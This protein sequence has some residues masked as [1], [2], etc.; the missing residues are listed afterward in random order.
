MSLFRP[1]LDC[2]V[3]KRTGTNIYGEE[4][5]GVPVAARCSVIEMRMGI[6][7][8]SVRADSSASRG[9]AR[10]YIGEAK[11]LFPATADIDLD[12]QVEVN[13]FKL[14]ITS[15]FPRHSLQGVLDHFEVQAGIWGR[16]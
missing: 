11:L 5:L 6:E 1:N 8:S 2:T 12:D 7:R 10:E 13:G 4:A 15:F 9:S 14:R 3:R 16:A